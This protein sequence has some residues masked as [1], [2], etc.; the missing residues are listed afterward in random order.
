[1][2]YKTNMG[3][4]NNG[5]GGEEILTTNVQWFDAKLQKVCEDDFEVEEYLRKRT[6]CKVH[7]GCH[8][9]FT[10]LVCVLNIL[11]RSM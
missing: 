5:E 7:M 6:I 10:I 3:Q 4:I 9:C 2:V 1:M 11:Y 8:T